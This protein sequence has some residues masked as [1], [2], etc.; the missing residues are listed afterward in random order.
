MIPSQH[1]DQLYK[2]L[3]DAYR[4]IKRLSNENLTLK[5]DIE[6]SEKTLW[7][8]TTS[9][10]KAKAD[11]IAAKDTASPAEQNTPNSE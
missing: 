8:M 7:E 6:R 4:E 10:Y 5:N 9:L 1:Y 3:N 2:Q 11:L